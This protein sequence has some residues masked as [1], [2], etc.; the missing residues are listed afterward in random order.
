M[1]SDVQ[2][3]SLGLYVHVPFC[4]RVCPY[5]DFA[6]V[7]AR[8]LESALERR[9]V[10][11][12][13]REWET[14][15]EAFAAMRLATVYFGGGTPSLL[16]PQSLA[17]V[18]DAVRECMGPLDPAVEITLEVNPSTTER[19]RLPE[20]R[21]LGINRLSVGVQSFDDTTLKRLGRAHKAGEGIATLRAAREAGF[22]NLSL[23][24]IVACPGQT[25]ETFA[26]DLECALGFAPE[27]LSIYELTIEQGTPFALAEGR[28]QLAR[29]PEELAIAM[30][31]HLAE[32]C[33]AAGLERYEISN[34]ARPGFE[35]AH[36]AR[37]WRRE[38]VL[39]IGMGA[40]SSQRPGGALPNGGRQM[41]PRTLALYLAGVESVACDDASGIEVDALSA[42]QARSEAVFLGLR[43]SVGLDAAAFETEFGAPPRKFYSE[44]IDRL[45]AH[46]LLAE[47]KSGD[48]RLTERGVLLSDTVFADFV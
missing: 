14:R 21:A 8:P 1:T 36:N 41:N 22:E 18:L 3:E 47:T 35:S 40:W 16:S 25:F 39:G 38:P 33:G 5:C 4:E 7:A 31:E 19:E 13:V 10:D 26:A 27:H 29:P 32:R 11:A 48:L 12:L 37:Y 46:G 30:L 42:E 43:R 15:S 45:M 34:Y 44:Q 6:V 17:R 2:Q 28:G 9:Y 24:L 20:F 23:D